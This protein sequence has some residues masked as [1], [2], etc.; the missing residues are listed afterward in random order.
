MLRLT[1]LLGSL[2]STLGEVDKAQMERLSVH[3]QEMEYIAQ[4]LTQKAE[5][6]KSFVEK[7]EDMTRVRW[8]E[9]TGFMSNMLLIDAHLNVAEY[10]KTYLFDPRVTSVLCSATLTTSK[11]FDFVRERMGLSPRSSAIS[12]HMY[13]SPFDYKNR[14]LLVGFKDIALP[15]HPH[16]I[17]RSQRLSARSYRSVRE[18]VLSCSHH[19]ICSGR[20]MALCRG[21]LANIPCLNKVMRRGR[22]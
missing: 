22:S 11:R 7:E 21:V 18:A 12:E 15:T 14:A 19:T 8:V 1:T 2:R 10:L 13:P 16:F 5:E 17:Q 4:V 9:L 3:L 20:C 6:L